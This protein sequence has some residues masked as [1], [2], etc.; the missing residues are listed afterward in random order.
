MK[1]LNKV[2]VFSDNKFFL[3]ILK[4]YFYANR[5]DMTE[6]RFKTECIGEIE[7]IKP[8]LLLFSLDYLATNRNFEIALLRRICVSHKITTC[9]LEDSLAIEIEK[10][11]DWIDKAIK[12]CQDVV[13]LDQYIKTIFLLGRGSGEDRRHHER[14][15]CSERRSNEFHSVGDEKSIHAGYSS[16]TKRQRSEIGMQYFED[17]EIDHR[18]KYVIIKGRRIELTRKEFELFELLSTDVDRIF[19]AEEI[20]QYLWPENNRASKSDLYQYMHLLRKKVEDDPNNPQWVITV[21]GF[22]YRLNVKHSFGV[23]V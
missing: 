8:D 15:S 12:N 23:G 7:K 6:C 13:E 19:L 16:N 14:R 9:G 5:V 3:A 20:I 17:F 22:G 1:N 18:N 4:G 21:K 2:S 11:P 10:L